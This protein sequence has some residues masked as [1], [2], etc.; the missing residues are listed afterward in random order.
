FFGA[1]D[2]EDV[3]LSDEIHETRDTVGSMTQ[4]ETQAKQEELKKV[5]FLDAYDE[6]KESKLQEG[7][8]A[9]MIE[10]FDI[11]TRIGKMLGKASTL[12]KLQQKS[13]PTMETPNAGKVDSATGAVNEFFADAFQKETLKE[14]CTEQLE[15]LEAKLDDIL[16]K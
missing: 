15:G 14:S 6:F 2:D 12:Q 1:Q 7:F 11:A 16:H 4:R 13:N 9:G 10:T 8:E 5:A 3:A